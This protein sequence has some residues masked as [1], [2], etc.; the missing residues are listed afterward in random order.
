MDGERPEARC[1]W[2]QPPVLEEVSYMLFNGRSLCQ[3]IN[4]GISDKFGTH[5]GRSGFKTAPGGA[6]AGLIAM[7]NRFGN[8]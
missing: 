5:V 6:Q 7:G 3:L 1:T 4:P 2:Q 8:V